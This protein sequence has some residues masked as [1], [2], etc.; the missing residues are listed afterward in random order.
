MRCVQCVSI[1]N[2]NKKQRNEFNVYLCVLAH[3]PPLDPHAHDSS[4]YY[5]HML[6][7][8]FWFRNCSRIPWR[9]QNER[10]KKKKNNIYFWHLV[11]D[12]D[13]SSVERVLCVTP[14]NAK[15]LH[16]QFKRLAI[17]HGQQSR[18]KKK[19]TCIALYSLCSRSLGSPVVR[20]N[21]RTSKWMKGRNDMK[22]HGKTKGR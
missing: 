21:Y 4:D 8:N 1:D 13:G 19:L 20:N 6:N 9:M 16:G 5:A 7:S 17:D 10:S 2:N 3:P 12:F 15:R 11:Y 22:R 14:T 18:K